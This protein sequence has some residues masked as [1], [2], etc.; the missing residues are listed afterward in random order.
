VHILATSK[1]WSQSTSAQAVLHVLHTVPESMLHK[2][3]LQLMS[4][5]ISWSLPCLQSS[6]RR[7]E[8][9]HNSTDVQINV[10]NFHCNNIL[11]DHK[12][13]EDLLT[14]QDGS[15]YTERPEISTK[16]EI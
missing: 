10:S 15:D 9:F 7:G 3:V 4:T 6:L 11:T 1:L 14:P 12:S 16:F 13:L 8:I 2:Y 5:P